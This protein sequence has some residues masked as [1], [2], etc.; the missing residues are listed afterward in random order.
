MGIIDSHVHLYPPEMNRD[1][2]GWAAANGEA[3]WS[4]LCARRRGDGRPVQAFP[5]VDGMLAL[6][7]ESGI[8][9]VVLMGWYWERPE[10]CS[11]Q[12]RFFAECV[13]AHPDRLAG[14]AALHPAA[15]R[16]GTLAEMRRAREEG[17]SGIGEMFPAAQGFSAAD[18]VFREALAE[19]GKL[20]LPATLHATDPDGPAYPGRLGTPDGDFLRLARD[21]PSTVL[22]LAHWGG[23]LPLRSPEAAA[24]PN[25]RYDTAASPLLYDGGVWRDFVGKVGPD[26]VL[27]GSDFPL[28]LYPG[29]DPGPSWTRL[30]AEVRESGLDEAALSAVLRGNAEGLARE[31]GSAPGGVNFR[32]CQPL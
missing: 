2:E 22:I 23:M 29:R 9:R 26:R 25:L 7:D 16:E 4:R 20:R 8:E 6:M 24:L 30:V 13:R 32:D 11:R 27:F 10:S 31:C 18:P 3:R 12:N 21:F 28:N 5:A 15:G 19:A 1:P 17:L 14:F